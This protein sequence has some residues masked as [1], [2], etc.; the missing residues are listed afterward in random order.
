MAIKKR[1]LWGGKKKI[2]IYKML[3][4]MNIH[5]RFTSTRLSIGSNDSETL[6]SSPLY[7]QDEGYLFEG[8]F[9]AVSSIGNRFIA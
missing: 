5:G 9:A 2:N 7:L 1:V 3:F 8:E 4:V 6:T